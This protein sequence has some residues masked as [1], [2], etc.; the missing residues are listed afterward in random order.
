MSILKKDSILTYTAKRLQALK[1]SKYYLSKKA[2]GS[3]KF[4]SLF[5]FLFYFSKTGLVFDLTFQF[6][7]SMSKSVRFMDNTQSSYFFIFSI[8]LGFE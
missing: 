4:F 1:F 8:L 3:K 5:F 6:R 2:S 7:V